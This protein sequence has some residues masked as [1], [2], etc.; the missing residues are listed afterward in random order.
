[1]N[2]SGLSFAYPGKPIFHDLS[3]VLPERGLTALSGTSGCGKTTLLRLI[4]GLETPQ[5]GRIGGPDPARIALMFQED[6]LI[7]RLAARRQI[8]L[9]RPTGRSADAW[10]EAVGLGAEGDTPPESLSGGMRRRLALAR[11]LAY[12][13]DK[14]LLLLDEPFTGVDAD[15]IRSLIALIREMDIPTLFTAHDAESLQMADTIIKLPKTEKTE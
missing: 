3:L 1:M 13:E 6:R 10:L 11:C 5:A 8:A 7:P 4:A 15:R 9:V 14:A 2:I 12:G